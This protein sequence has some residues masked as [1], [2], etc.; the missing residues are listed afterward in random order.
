MLDAVLA[1]PETCLAAV[2]SAARTTSRPS[3]SAGSSCACGAGGARR[4]EGVARV[5]PAASRRLRAIWGLWV[6]VD[7]V[8]EAAARR[9]ARAARREARAQREAAEA[10]RVAYETSDEGR[11]DRLLA[12]DPAMARRLRPSDSRKVR[13]ALQ[14]CESTG[15]LASSIF[16]SGRAEASSERDERL[17]SAPAAAGAR[18]AATAGTKWGAGGALRGGR[19]G[20]GGEAAAEAVEAVEAAVEAARSPRGSADA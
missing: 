11:N 12:V 5:A 10:A 15:R 2:A 7:L 14:H 18:R 20:R 8:A 3:R 19:G 4:P 9:Q 17:S 16:L 1:R 13:R 6:G